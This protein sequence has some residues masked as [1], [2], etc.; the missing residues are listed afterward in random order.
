MGENPALAANHGHRPVP[1]LAASQALL[2]R[3]ASAASLPARHRRHAADRCRPVC[4][5]TWARAR[6]QTRADSI[7]SG[8]PDSLA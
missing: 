8:M 2:A 5:T 3:T 4:T 7:L 6:L 1:W